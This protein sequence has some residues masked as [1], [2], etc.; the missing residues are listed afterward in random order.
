MSASHDQ[1]TTTSLNIPRIATL[2]APYAAL[3]QQQLQQTSTYLQLLLKWNARTNLTSIRTPEQIISRH[4]GESFFAA[5]RLVVDEQALS[6]IDLGSGAGFPGLPLAMVAPAASVTLIESNAK[7]VAFLNE[8][9]HALSLRNASTSKQRGEEYPGKA[10]LVVM[11]AVENFERSALVAFSLLQ[12]QGRLAL[13]I[14]E[15]QV[16]Q[17]KIAL[18]QMS[19]QTPVLLPGSHSRVLLAGTRKVR[20]E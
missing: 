4:F 11:R 17:A 10:G 3:D 15:A 2:L 20:V 6:V 16:D 1:E 8:V 7:K 13:M 14:G 9:I 12:P 5:R 19:W 18:P